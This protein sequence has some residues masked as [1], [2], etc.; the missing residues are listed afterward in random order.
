MK[1]E[2]TP[3]RD[4]LHVKVMEKRLDA[5]VATAF[6]DRMRESI[7]AAGGSVLVDLRHVDFMDSSGLGAMISVFKGMPPGR[8][9]ELTGL[10]PNVERVLRLT[11][12]DSVFTIRPEIGTDPEGS[13]P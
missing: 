7:S 13:L 12:M 9:L 10:T 6:K 8:V 3:L 1:L 2:I 11:R 5:V 4:H